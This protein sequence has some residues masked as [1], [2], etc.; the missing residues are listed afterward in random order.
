MFLDCMFL[1][2]MFLNCMCLIVEL[3][4][5]SFE[6]A[7]VSAYDAMKIG[8]LSNYVS[9]YIYTFTAFTRYLIACANLHAPY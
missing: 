2:C 7:R 9:I 8:Q 3:D 1:D 5:I 6:E 4:D